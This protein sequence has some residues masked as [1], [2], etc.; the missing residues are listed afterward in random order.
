MFGLLELCKYFKLKKR[1]KIFKDAS[2]D[3]KIMWKTIEKL[4]L[5][6]SKIEKELKIKNVEYT[7]LH[8][9]M[10]YTKRQIIKIKSKGRNNDE[11]I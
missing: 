4:L 9:D 2:N 7:K 11:C 3:V 5:D 8:D 10:K 6:I 1:N